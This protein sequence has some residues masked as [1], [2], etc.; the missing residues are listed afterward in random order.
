MNEEGQHVIADIKRD[1]RQ[2]RYGRLSTLS[3]KDKDYRQALRQFKQKV[4]S[5]I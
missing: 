3:S 1:Y 5:L 2:L 4:R